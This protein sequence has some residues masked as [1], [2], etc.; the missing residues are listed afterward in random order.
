MFIGLNTCT[1]LLVNLPELP[2]KSH[3]VDN[4][5]KVIFFTW[6]TV[7]LLFLF[8]LSTFLPTAFVK[9]KDEGKGR[10]RTKK[11]KE[12]GNKLEKIK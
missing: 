3:R 9:E 11:K 10:S 7:V 1:I 2:L 12:K 5:F 4:D 8:F 6:A